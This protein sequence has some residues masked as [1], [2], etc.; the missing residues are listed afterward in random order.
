[1]ITAEGVVS[2]ALAGCQ[3][4][5]DKSLFALIR[6][7]TG[8]SRGRGVRAARRS[9]SVSAAALLELIHSLAQ[10]FSLP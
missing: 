7:V 6:N 8:V 4:S 10:T 2:T 9:L 1:M 5:I 3:N